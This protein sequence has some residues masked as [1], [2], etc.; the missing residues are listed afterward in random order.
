MLLHLLHG[1]F[2]LKCISLYIK[3]GKQLKYLFDFSLQPQ[4][5]KE[6][7][8]DS[9]RGNYLATNFNFCQNFLD[10]ELLL[11]YTDCILIFNRII[12]LHLPGQR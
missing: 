1:L 12:D 6:Y 4:D 8:C 10:E 5:I 3:I 11:L 9:G 2:F 7:F